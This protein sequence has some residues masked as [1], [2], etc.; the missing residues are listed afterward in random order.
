MRGGK[1]ERS[2]VGANTFLQGWNK[3]PRWRVYFCGSFDKP[4][5]FKTFMGTNSNG[6]ELE[7]MTG[8]KEVEFSLNRLGA[9]FAF[10]DTE[11]QSRVGVSFIS[12]EQAC[13]NVNDEIPQGTELSDLKDAAQKDWEDSVLSK[14]TTT[15]KD[16]EKLAQL[17]SALY[18]MNLLPTNK[19]G[20]NPLWKSKEPYY[21]DIFTFWDTVCPVFPSLFT[22]FCP[23]KVS[24]VNTRQFRCT[25][26]LFHILQPKAYEEFIRSW[27]DIWRHEGFMSDGRSS[28]WSG[29]VQA[30]SN[31]DNVFADAYVKG[32][33]GEVDWDDAYEAMMTDAEVVPP[34]GDDNR[35]PGGSAKE[36]RGALSDWLAHGYITTKFVRSVTRAVE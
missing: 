34:L 2:E 6:E 32:V 12:T 3:S 27:I 28:F 31:V 7:R 20:E 8:E 4:A 1:C 35:D 22:L 36:G 21:D 15:E 5:S 30:G 10:Q 9:V 14:I 19:T 13:R 25:T 16:P 17:Y 24:E 26:S 29:S 23:S 18:F 33:R 11:V